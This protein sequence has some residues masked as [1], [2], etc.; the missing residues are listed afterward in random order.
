M[1]EKISIIIPARN[2]EA[3]IA[4][5]I[6]V[7]QEMP[8]PD[9]EIIIVDGNSTDRTILE[10]KKADKVISCSIPGRAYQMNKGAN[11][12]TGDILWFIHAD[13]QFSKSSSALQEIEHTLH[14]PQIAAGCLKIRF[15]DSRKPFFLY[16]AATSTWR[17]K[18]LKLIFG[19][20]G[21]FVRKK[22]FEQSGGYPDVSLME[23]WLMSRQ[24]R[25]YGKFKVISSEIGTSARR[26]IAGG[27]LRV[28]LKMHWIKLL[29]L[30]GC[31][32]D[33]LRE[34]YEGKDKN[35]RSHKKIS[36]KK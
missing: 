3:R 28:H 18:Y 1:N 34:I 25:Q 2:E 9:R 6:A 13:S 29:F 16:L 26:F 8:G 30:F 7:L 19:D 36:S 22:D 5:L 12:A 27:T 4:G 10:A 11:E 17:A 14:N 23:D 31:S 15:V 33:R 20:Q 24:L 32:T 21:L 35:E